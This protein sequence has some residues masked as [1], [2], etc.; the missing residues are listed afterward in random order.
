[1]CLSICAC[2]ASNNEMPPENNDKMETKVQEVTKPTLLSGD[3]KRLASGYVSSWTSK[4]ESAASRYNSDICSVSAVQIG[5][6]SA[7]KKSDRS[8]SDIY[9]ITING[10]F[11]GK[12]TYGR[13]IAQYTYTWSVEIDY[14]TKS[15]NWM[16]YRWTNDNIK[17]SK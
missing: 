7:D 17:N 10:T 6:V 9:K 1:M 2:A 14:Y 5:S 16:S 8:N 4:L 13:I 3:A 12:D 11:Y 15:N